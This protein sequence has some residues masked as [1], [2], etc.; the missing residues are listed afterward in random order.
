MDIDA[1]DNA[2]RSGL[3]RGCETDD[4]ELVKYLI[5][6]GANVK[7]TDLKSRTLL[8]FAAANGQVSAVK[9][10]LENSADINH[11]DYYTGADLINL[12][13]GKDRGNIFHKLF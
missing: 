1:R 6:K 8:H 5:T 2:G 7:A 12:V 10:L 11:Q 9:C 4:I 3:M 13:R